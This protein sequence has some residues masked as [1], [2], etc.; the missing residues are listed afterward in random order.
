MEIIIVKTDE[1]ILGYIETNIDIDT[2]ETLVD[3]SFETKAYNYDIDELVKDI[4]NEG[5]SADRYDPYSI[6]I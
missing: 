5:Y 3:C 2:L 6:E 1:T 4:E